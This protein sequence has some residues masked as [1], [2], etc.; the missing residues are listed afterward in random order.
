MER[1]TLTINTGNDA[2]C[3]SVAGGGYYACVAAVA[4]LLRAV[5]DRIEIRCDFDFAIFDPNGNVVGK[6]ESR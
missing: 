1:I 5:A 3:E 4:Q 2:F 6:V